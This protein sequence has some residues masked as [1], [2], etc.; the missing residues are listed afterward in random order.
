MVPVMPH[1]PTVFTRKRASVGG[2]QTAL[3][4]RRY[5]WLAGTSCSISARAQNGTIENQVQ[6]CS[7][8]MGQNRL[9]ENR[10]RIT[11]VPPAHSEAS[12]E[13]ACALVWYSGSATR[14]TSSARRSSCTAFTRAPQS[15]LA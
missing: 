4:Q 6:R 14:C 1:Q 13:Y 12:T 3:P 9:A 7:T 10:G 11:A 5:E 15:A 2:S 8:E